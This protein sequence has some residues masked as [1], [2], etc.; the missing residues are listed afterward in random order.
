MQINKSVNELIDE[1]VD[2]LPLIRRRMAKRWLKRGDH[3]E[4]LADSMLLK[5]CEADDVKAMG[6][7]EGFASGRIGADTPIGFDPENLRKILDLIVEYL[8]TILEI[9]L[10]LFLSLALPVAIALGSF[11]LAASPAVADEPMPCFAPVVAEP[12]ELPSH[13][14]AQWGQWGQQ[15]GSCPGGV[16]PAP[17]PAPADPK[18]MKAKISILEP[19]EPCGRSFARRRPVR[20]VVSRI[21]ALFR[22]SRR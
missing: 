3:R 9:I 4:E 1:A 13:V 17:K 12:P 16:C 19:C 7:A 15:R 14:L 6:L 22:I 11:A 20:G 21:L 10:P 8:P 18:I 2:G 5:L